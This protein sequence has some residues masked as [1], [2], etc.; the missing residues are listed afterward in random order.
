M[1]SSADANYG[2]DLDDYDGEYIPE[3]DESSNGDESDMEKEFPEIPEDETLDEEAIQDVVQ[4]C[5]S[6]LVEKELVSLYKLV[7][8]KSKMMKENKVTRVHIKELT[9]DMQA[10]APILWKLLEMIVHTKSQEKRN[11]QKNPDNVSANNCL[12]STQH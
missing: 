5:I 6:D 4:K 8:N 7:Y 9:K 1:A 12:K 3:D 2:N 10:A 11:K